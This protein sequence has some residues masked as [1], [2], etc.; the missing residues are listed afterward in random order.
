M[1]RNL[2]KQLL[3]M[4]EREAD[5]EMEALQEPA[6]LP[7]I[8]IAKRE[9]DISILDNEDAEKRA[10]RKALEEVQ[11]AAEESLQDVQ[12]VQMGRCPACGEHLRQHLFASVCESCGWHAFDTP[13]EGQVKVHL[14]GRE[15]PLVGDHGYVVKDGT[16]LVISHGVVIARVSQEALSWIEYVW[17]DDEVK[18]RHTQALKRLGIP[19]AWCSKPVDP[20]KDGFHI[21]HVALGAFQERHC[22]CSDEC[23]S[24]FKKMYPARVHR[25]CYERDCADCD[26]CMK[27]YDDESEGIR[28]IAREHSKS[29]KPE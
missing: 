22:F 2:F 11:D 9:K 20:H 29:K 1:N 17:L 4:D 5:R 13:R 8:Q 19:C 18:E 24:A 16:I 23:F 26:L 28:L 3:G 27:R 6:I 7:D 21:S 12:V 15:A 14:K 10:M 25:N